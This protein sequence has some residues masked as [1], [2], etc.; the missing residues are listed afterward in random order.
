MII[1]ILL[2]YGLLVCGVFLLSDSSFGLSIAPLFKLGMIAVFSF[3][4]LLVLPIYLC[5]S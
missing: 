2:L 1:I 4:V 5:S 3:V